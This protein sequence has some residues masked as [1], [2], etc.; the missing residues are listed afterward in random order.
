MRHTL[1]RPETPICPFAQRKAAYALTQRLEHGG[2]AI[3]IDPEREVGF[4]ECRNGYRGQFWLAGRT[5]LGADHL[6]PRP[7]QQGLIRLQIEV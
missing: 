7:V 2:Y 4:F 3:E 6:L 5:F 1:F